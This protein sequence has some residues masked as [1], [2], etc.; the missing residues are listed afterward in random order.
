M[1]VADQLNTGQKDLRHKIH[2]TIQKV[3]DD[4]GRRYTFNTAIAANMELLNDLSAYKAET[5]DDH[6][7][8]REGIEAIVLMLSPI[9]PHICSELWTCL[10]HA[11]QV[12]DQVWPKAD[13]EALQRDSI[14]LIVQINGKLRDK[15]S[16]D[17]NADDE[18][19]KTAALNSEKILARINDQPVK[20]VIVVKGRLVNIVV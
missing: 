13:T 20:K 9:V 5:E 10:G 12:E 18:V 6:A 16:I 19:I 1:C 2:S 14:E 4:V 15:I 3:S 17:A 7:I 8:V 11:S